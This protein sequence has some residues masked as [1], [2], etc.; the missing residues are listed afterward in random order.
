MIINDVVAL[1]RYDEALC[2]PIAF[3]V[4]YC[5]MFRP[6]SWHSGKPM[7]LMRAID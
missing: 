6:K 2:H 5:N 4:A 1:H 7:R 3:L